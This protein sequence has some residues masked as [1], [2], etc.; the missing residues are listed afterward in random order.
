[1]IK[2][3]AI[4]TSTRA[5]YGLLKPIIDALGSAKTFDVKVLVTGTHLSESFGF[6]C[7]EIEADGVIIDAK[8][9]ILSQN[10]TPEAV[11]NSMAAALMG[12]SEY[13]SKSRPDA[14]LVLGDRYE[15]LAVCCAAM[16]SCIPIIHLHGGE[17]TQGAID[18]AVRH[19]ITKM[20]HIHFTSNEI[21]RK[22]V[23]QL[24]ENPSRVFNVGATGVENVLK[25]QFM[26]KKE[27]EKSIDFKLDKA[28]GLVTFHPVTLEAA[29]AAKQFEELEKA[30]E[31][32]D[33]MEFII[34]KANADAG[35]RTIN[36]MIDKFCEGH[37]NIV[38]FASLGMT[39][40][41][42][43]MKQCSVVIGNSSSGIIEAPSF[44]VTT[45]NI[46]IRQKG[47]MQAMSVINCGCRREYIINAIKKARSETFAKILPHVINP[48]GDGNTS[49]KIAEILERVF[50]EGNISLEKEF[51]DV[52]FNI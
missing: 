41:L 24:G 14:L 16:N 22:R 15:T 36:D 19:S 40:Y 32:F 50:E 46:G 27:L 42:S 5:E 11:S 1:M 33:D 25:T 9:D 13:F 26:S 28:F 39:R 35:G 45:V 51:Y 10:D 30:L 43:A 21:H 4:L 2:S 8:I 18:E 49:Q 34:T 31:Y 47:R 20:S 6:T 48:Y 37:Q 17:T 52:N 44:K 38:A 29:S 7:K 3:I 23:I 12:F